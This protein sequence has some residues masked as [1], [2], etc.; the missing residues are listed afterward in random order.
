MG[1][2]DSTPSV[3][4]YLDYRR[5]LAEWFEAKKA[6]NPRYSHRAFVRRTGQRSPSVLADV[7]AG[8]RSLTTAGVE[9]FVRALGPAPAE[10]RFFGW[11]VTLDQ[12]ETPAE[13]NAVWR[14][15]SATK[16]FRESR[17]LEGDS[18]RYLSTWY[19]P[20]VRELATRPDFRA[21]PAWI[22]RQ[23]DPPIAEEEARDALQLLFDLEMLAYDADGRVTHGGGSLVTPTEIAALAVTNYHQGMLDRAR[24]ALSRFSSEQ[25]HFL[26]V[27]VAVPP[28]LLPR[29]KEELNAMQAKLLDLCSDTEDGSTD[30]VVQVN[31]HFFPLSR[32]GPPEEAP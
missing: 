15:I 1:R 32:P 19:V 8:R 4:G 26:A 5:F 18:V 16:R 25:R 21:D 29:L 31:L 2:E 3:Y 9:G 12:A 27:T 23:V 20:V 10:A 22:A 30:Q 28:S 7:I 11:L 13:R 24:E 17:R 14:H 6:V